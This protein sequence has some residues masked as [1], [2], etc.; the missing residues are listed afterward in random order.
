MWI[1]IFLFAFV[2]DKIITT[3]KVPVPENLVPLLALNWPSLFQSL[4]ILSSWV[5][6]IYEAS[7]HRTSH[8]FSSDSKSSYSGNPNSQYQEF[9]LGAD[10]KGKVLKITLT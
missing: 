7:Q 4:R 10:F 9:C 8:H 3:L 1:L 5:F 6:L 2:L